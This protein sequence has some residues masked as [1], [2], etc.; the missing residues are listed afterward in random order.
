MLNNPLL[1]QSPPPQK[2]RKECGAPFDGGASERLAMLTAGVPQCVLRLG[3]SQDTTAALHLSKA[4]HT[5]D[6]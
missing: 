3:R 4:A 6:A 5:P 1:K 2:D